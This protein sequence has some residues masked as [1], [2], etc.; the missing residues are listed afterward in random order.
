MA[1]P[2]RVDFSLG[3]LKNENSS[4]TLQLLSDLY[5]KINSKLNNNTNS[6]EVNSLVKDV[7][8]SSIENIQ[9]VESSVAGG[10]HA[11]LNI[12][13]SENLTKN[14]YYL[15]VD[16]NSAS[17]GVSSSI[18]LQYDG[19]ASFNRTLFVL[20]AIDD[21]NVVVTD[22]IKDMYYIEDGDFDTED[23]IGW[24]LNIG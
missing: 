13:F 2:M 19:S 1:F 10:T 5:N 7:P 14:K 17:I 22:V 4:A 11:N 18:E 23:F 12:N 15:I 16:S 6:T 9:L 3:R 21:S 24:D 20:Q 8:M